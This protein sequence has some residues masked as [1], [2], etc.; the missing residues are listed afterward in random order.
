MAQYVLNEILQ[1]LSQ[2]NNPVAIP[3]HIK[4]FGALAFYATGSYQRVLGRSFDI[5]VSQQS[6]SKAIQE[7][8]SAIMNAM[9][10]QWVRFPRTD[11][12]KNDIK[13]K[14]MEATH[15]P[16]VIGAVDCTHV[17]IAQPPVE[18]HNYI[19]RKGYHSKNIQIVSDITKPMD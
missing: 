9:A 7:V 1:E 14:F 18:E 17:E 12:D 15:F 13:E 2:T 6:M 16:G 5:S 3:A 8:T 10:E 11:G 19:N 4:Y